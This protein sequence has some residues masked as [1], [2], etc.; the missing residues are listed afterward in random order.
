MPKRITHYGRYVGE[1]VELPRPYTGVYCV[2]ELSGMDNN[3][4]YVV[5]EEKWVKGKKA[6]EYIAD[7]VKPDGI[8]AEWCRTVAKT[9]A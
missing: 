1:L 3:R 6:E 7:G 8:V 2:I 4:V 9:P 5:P